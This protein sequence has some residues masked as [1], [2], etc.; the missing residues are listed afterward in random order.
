[1]SE[2]VARTAVAWAEAEG[3]NPGLDDAERFLAAAPDAFVAA[4]DGE[5]PTA[6]ASCAR[7]GG[8]YAFIGFF[9]VRPDLRGRGVGSAL[10]DRALTR[11]GERVVGLDAVLAQQ[12]YY[13]RR[14]FV[15]AYRNVRWRTAG[16]GDRPAGVL[17]LSA[18]PFETIAAFDAT[19][20]GAPRER[21]LTVWTDRPPGHALACVR[22]G[23]V[24]GYGVIR[25]CRVGAKVGP[26]FAADEEA[27][28]LLLEG[29]LAA[30]APGTEVFVDM[31]EANVAA[32]KLRTSRAMD[33]VFETVRMY[34][35]G[36]PREDPRKVYG[37]TTLEFG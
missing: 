16:G 7:Y 35:N 30:V 9:I 33:S 27:A 19:V 36:T 20:F 13:E 28:D 11:A 15:A 26:L 1:V 8:R 17:E 4:G 10:F 31:P 29:L 6:T 32:S 23:E 2:R 14:G 12:A 3:W 25:P 5:A 34:R 21:F 18:V 24:A 22:D 37:V